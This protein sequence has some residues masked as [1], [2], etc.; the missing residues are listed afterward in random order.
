VYKPLDQAPICGLAV[1]YISP[2]LDILIFPGIFFEQKSQVTNVLKSI[3][4]QGVHIKSLAVQNTYSTNWKYLWEALPVTA[5][6]E[7]EELII[8]LAYSKLG[9]DITGFEEVAK[10]KWVARTPRFTISY[11]GLCRLAREGF[12]KIQSKHPGWKAPKVRLRTFLY[13]L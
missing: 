6:C 5:L 10:E 13:A 7:M 1:D 4:D 9:Q 2:E 11:D 12:E 8:D 3:A